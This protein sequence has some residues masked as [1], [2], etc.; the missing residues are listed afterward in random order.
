MLQ[1]VAI[2]IQSTAAVQVRPYDTTLWARRGNLIRCSLG[3]LHSVLLIRSISRRP[4]LG[5]LGWPCILSALAWLPYVTS[6]RLS[7]VCHKIST[8]YQVAVSAASMLGCS[9]G[10]SVCFRPFLR[11]LI[12]PPVSCECSC[13]FLSNLCKFSRARCALLRKCSSFLL[14]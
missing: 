11:T 14:F 1:N 4:L 7:I 3:G 9:L 6:G 13:T 10:L 5:W 8:W 2:R 12:S